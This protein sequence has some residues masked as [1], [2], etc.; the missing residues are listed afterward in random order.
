MVRFLKSR[1]VVMGHIMAT[2]TVRGFQ[3]GECVSAL[4]KAVRRGDE[5][6]ALTWAV[7]IDQ[8]GF[9]SMLWSR[10]LVITSEDIGIAEP[11][12]PAVIRSLYDNYQTFVKRNNPNMPERLFVVH[13]VMLLARAKKSRIV[14]NA[15]WATYGIPEPL[16]AE[17]PDYA[18]DGH[19]ARGRSLKAGNTAETNREAFHLENEADVGPNPYNE[20]KTAWREQNG[21]AASKEMFKRQGGNKTV[22]QQDWRDAPPP[23]EPPH[24]TLL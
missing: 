5:Q 18:L 14:D 16:V 10:I 13:A 21:F 6:G 12:L 1:E 9:G 11:H 3:L 24:P 7:E 20:R 15:I 4:Q 23:E 8:S 2:R 22:S 17:I 19:T